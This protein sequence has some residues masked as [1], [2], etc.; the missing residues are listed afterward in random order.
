MESAKNKGS[1]YTTYALYIWRQYSETQQI[2]FD[3]KGM[4]W[5]GIWE[6]NRV[7]ELVQSSSTP[8]ASVELSQRNP[9]A[10]LRYDN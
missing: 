1:K 10:L 5:S 9:L 3:K 8:W 6:Y 7:Y 4:R 2:Q